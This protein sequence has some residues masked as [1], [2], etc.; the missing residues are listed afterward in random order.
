MGPSRE[1]VS[2]DRQ[3][4]P[5]SAGVMRQRFETSNR[6]DAKECGVGGERSIGD[7]AN[8]RAAVQGYRI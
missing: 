1:A 2:R 7:R 4:E 8:R 5:Q 3:D 6:F